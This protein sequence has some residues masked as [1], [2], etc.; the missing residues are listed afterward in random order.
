M[1]KLVLIS[2]S[3]PPIRCGVGYYSVRLSH[4]LAE[5]NVDFEILST[6]GVND[7]MPAPL[8]KVPDWKI[9]SL[10][11]MLSA[12]KASRAEIIHI[13]Y[14]AVGY[15][16]HLGIN[17]LPLILRLFKPRLKVLVTLHEYHDSRWLGRCRDFIT[18]ALAHKIIVSN[19]A[20]KQS[21]PRRLSRK[22]E[23]IPIGSNLT[24]VAKKAGVYTEILKH[25]KLDTKKPT[26]LF[27]GFAYPAKG[28]EIL[29]QAMDQPFLAGWQLL[30]LSSLDDAN[31]YHRE[32]LGQMAKINRDKP[33]VAAAGFLDD[34]AV[35]A[36]LQQGRY[37]VLPQSSPINAKSST[38][39]AAV[40]HNLTLISRASS[41][42]ELT[43]PFSH[44]ENCFLLPEVTAEAI[45]AAIKELEEL[46]GERQKIVNGTK[47]LEAY[48]SWNNIAKE[49]I[50]I[51]GGL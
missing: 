11:K 14:P 48:F 4:E 32:L 36:I 2:G 47:K 24:K 39:I 40:Q 38:A 1:K 42:P 33:R 5:Q 43:A 26:I 10:P 30:L 17:L 49:H 51:Y 50:K 28:L 9:R 37:F 23:L 12:I 46:S 41:Q 22:A 21:L 7:D 15:R 25:H 19:Y 3:L 16:R 35:S 34:G 8:L 29:I 13:Q 20:D 6:K 27:F 31:S 45:A 44:L 18:A